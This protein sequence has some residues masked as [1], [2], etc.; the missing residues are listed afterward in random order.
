M[1]NERKQIMDL[2]EKMYISLLEKTAKR[3]YNDS[4]YV[5]SDV[6]GYEC[7]RIEELFRPLWGIA[8]LLNEREMYIKVDEKRVKVTDFIT[9]VILKGTSPDSPLRFDRFVNDKYTF[10]NQAVTEIAAYLV[11]VYFA[12]DKLWDNLTDA[13]REQISSFILKWS[14]YAMNHSWPNN[15]YWYPI[16]CMEI[17]E[18][19]GYDCSEGKE[20]KEQGYKNLEA[21]YLDNGWYMDGCF[22]RF[23]YYHAWAH[24]TYTLLWIL[25]ADKNAPGYKE[26]AET[27]KKRSEEYIKFYSHQFDSDGGMAAYGRSLSYRFAAVSIFG[28]AA[29]VGCD[30]DYSMAKSVVTKNIKYFFE[31]SIEQDDK[32]FPVG[33]LY[34]APGFGEGY[35]SEGASAC[36]TQGLMCLYADENNPLWSSDMGVL[37]I[38]EG[39]YK[40]KPPLKSV[41]IVVSGD[42]K[43]NG[44]TIFNNSIHY[45]QDEVFGHTFNDMSGFYGK[46]CYNS[47]SGYGIST[48][49]L[50]AADN[51]ISLV[52][53]DGRMFSERSEIVNLGDEEG[54]LI[55]SH[56]PY[57]NDANTIIKSYVI[58]LDNGY[59]VRVHDLTLSQPYKVVEG[60]FSVG[61]TDDGYTMECSTLKY[62]NYL[63]YINVTGVEGGY[64]QGLIQ[65]GMHLLKPQ[66][67]YPKFE[68][69]VL[70]EGRYFYAITVGFSTNGKLE[71]GPEVKIEGNKVTVKQG[72]TVKEI[73]L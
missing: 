30:I 32:T 21:L 45:Y 24:H 55:S 2:A 66:A 63:S 47:R 39:N 7:T 41:N 27:Y 13:Q 26:K 54:V 5:V 64:S 46:F 18:R 61:L 73:I 34:S 29:A 9:D 68:S 59:H 52:T 44:V 33:Y 38:E 42:D 17:L 50:V 14:I 31:N 12:K 53:P 72:E 3:F 36:Y 65:P 57:S 35:A 69:K 37:P 16:I 8:P 67:R 62:K 11:T 51:M 28:L 60:G 6:V 56:T 23:D 15:H 43:T 48:R 1:A 22:G 58:P 71:N 40:I 19:L 20:S 10:S 49:D 25:I 4:L 70:G